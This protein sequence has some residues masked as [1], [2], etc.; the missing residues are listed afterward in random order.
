MRLLN[1]IQRL[2]RLMGRRYLLVDF[3]TF[4]ERVIIDMNLLEM[5]LSKY[6]IVTIFL[7]VK[8]YDFDIPLIFFYGA[9][10]LHI[11][12]LGTR[13]LL[14]SNLVGKY[15]LIFWACSYN[16]TLLWAWINASRFGH[17]GRLRLRLLILIFTYFELFF[18][19][20]I[21]LKFLAQ[22]F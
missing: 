19:D 5:L 15:K 22:L 13:I 6:F 7:G 4:F 9:L 3:T 20:A 16:S 21:L 1:N 11:W 2:R 12:T 14:C 17:F 10:T 18:L 8:I